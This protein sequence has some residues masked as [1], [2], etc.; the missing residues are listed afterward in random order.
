MTAQQILSSSPGVDL[1]EVPCSHINHQSEWTPTQV[2][3]I[4]ICPTNAEAV[5]I[6]QFAYSVA[7]AASAHVGSATQ[8]LHTA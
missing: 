3:D 6:A 1:L 2:G 7:C 4:W 8:Y 5:R